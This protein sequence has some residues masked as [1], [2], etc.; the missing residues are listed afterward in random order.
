[1]DEAVNTFEGLGLGKN[2]IRG[3]HEMGFKEPFP[4]Q[5]RTIGPILNGRDIIGQAKSGSG[6]TAAFGLPLLQ[7]IGSKTDSIQAL[8]VAPTRELAVQITDEIRRMGKYTG[9]RAVAVYGGQSMRVQLDQLEKGVQ[10]A[11]GTPGRLID[12]IDRRFL[13]LS[14]VKYVVL[15]EADRMLDMGF[16]EGVER[17]LEEV[18]SRR[19]MSL[20]SA[21]MPEQIIE[22]AAKYMTKPEKIFI[23]ADELSVDDLDQYYTV[24]DED[25]K[26]DRLEAI[27]KKE[28]PASCLIFCRTK[29]RTRR[30][31]RS[32][33]KTF[34]NVMSIHGDLSQS[35]RNKSLEA[36]RKG[37]AEVLVA[38]E[39]AARG[40]DVPGIQ[41]VLNYDFP[42]DP[43]MYFHRIGRTAR[44][45]SG[46][47]SI[48]F[49]SSH[50]SY[51][52]NQVKR[53]TRASIKPLLPD[54]ERKISVKNGNFP[55]IRQGRFRSS[56]RQHKFRSSNARQGFRSS[57]A[58]QG[59]RSSNARQGFRSSNAR[60]GFRS[61][62]AR[63]GFRSSNARQFRSRRR[64]AGTSSVNH[65]IQHNQG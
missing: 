34:N 27:L 35:Q 60:Q 10:I 23:S 3:L 61:S 26:F 63:Q 33:D 44:G 58:R 53:M 64:P 9:I 55:H 21:T 29:E 43:F 28:K 45:G 49:V 62:N 20:F 14:S 8:I 59:F 19:Q 17:I 24:V 16:I 4:I 42:L 1:M 48:S 37:E 32:L 18:P 38:T 57:N 39:V 65:D 12:F 47:K 52:F 50:D 40:I 31:S 30:L 2:L 11:V 15:D 5:E 7:M 25:E 54:D 51:L 36:F 6:K 46:G 56:K 41:L 22:L 13:D